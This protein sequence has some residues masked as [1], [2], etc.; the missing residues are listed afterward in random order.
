[1]PITEGCHMTLPP[2]KTAFHGTRFG[3][4]DRISFTWPLPWGSSGIPVHS[5]NL[6]SS[7]M[8][9][10]NPS[11]SGFDSYTFPVSRIG[12]RPGDFLLLLYQ[13][14]IYCSS[15][16][17]PYS[18][19]SQCTVTWVTISQSEDLFLDEAGYVLQLCL[20]PLEPW[21]YKDWLCFRLPQTA[22]T[23]TTSI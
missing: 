17:V 21:D 3:E 11:V 4:L 9:C 6:V 14:D 19:Y 13:S 15:W 8:E 20:S 23:G 5:W 2:L 12:Q 10:S 7:S 16:N 22:F 18:H 1:M